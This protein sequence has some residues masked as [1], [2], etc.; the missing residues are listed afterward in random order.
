MNL[1]ELYDQTPVAGHADILVSG[2][3]VYVRSSE[4]VEEY[5][6]LPDGE[7]RLLRSDKVNPIAGLRQ[8]LANIKAKLGI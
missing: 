2:D 7:I 4:G 5:L 1:K 6:L 3:R 8:D